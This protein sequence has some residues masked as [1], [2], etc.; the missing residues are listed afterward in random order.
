MR[1]RCPPV[2]GCGGAVRRGRDATQYQE[3]LPVER[4]IVRQF[5]IAIGAAGSVT[6]ACKAA[7]P[8][9]PPT[10]SV[11]RGAARTDGGELAVILNKQFGVPLGKIVRLFRERF[12]LTVT[13]GGLVHAI[14]RA[15]RQAEPTYDAC[16]HDPRQPG[17]HAR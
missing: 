17:R 15:A 10:R 14:R 7:I 16:A 3:D 4:P 13:S 1:R 2:S 6:V 11:P 5:C 8:C 9:K 12:G